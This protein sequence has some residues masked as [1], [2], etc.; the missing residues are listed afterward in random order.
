MPRACSLCTH[1]DRLT[2]ETAF[3][4]GLPLRTIAAQWSVS[5]T[6]LLRHRDAHLPI[7]PSLLPYPRRTPPGLPSPPKQPACSSS[8]EP[9]QRRSNASGLKTGTGRPIPLV[10]CMILS[11]VSSTRSDDSALPWA[12]IQS[13]TYDNHSLWRCMHEHTHTPFSPRSAPRPHEGDAHRTAAGIH[14]W[15]ARAGPGRTLSGGVLR[16]PTWP[17]AGAGL[18]SPAALEPGQPVAADSWAPCRAAPQAAY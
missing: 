8:V 14:G 2:I 4:G 6:A 13:V 7:A 9:W 17:D 1:P 18:G 12:S 15:L 11:Y 16:L 5:K 3:R 10:W